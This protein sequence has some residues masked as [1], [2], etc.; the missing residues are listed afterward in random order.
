MVRHLDSRTR[1][2]TRDIL[3]LICGGERKMQSMVLLCS[4]LLDGD[5]GMGLILFRVTR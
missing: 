1:T 2:Y 4:F 5:G 3:T